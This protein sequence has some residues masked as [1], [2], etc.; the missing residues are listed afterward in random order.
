MNFKSYSLNVVGRIIFLAASMMAFIYALHQ[1]QWYVTT[2]VTGLLIPVLIF[3]LIRYTYRFQKELSF[4]L[5]AIRNREYTQ[6][7]KEGLT[8]KRSEL[9]NAFHV[10]SKE[11]QNV[12]IEKE[13]HYNYLQALVNNINIGI[14]SYLTS[15]EIQLFNKSA[16][17]LLNMPVPKTLKHI[18]AYHPNLYTLLERANPGGKNVLTI[19][20][21]DEILKIAVQVKEFKQQSRIYKLISLQDIR[22]ELDAQELESY[23]KLIQVLRHEIMN[24]VTPIYSL[25]ES[26]KESIEEILENKELQGSPVKEELNDLLIS[27]TTIHTRTNGLLKFVQNYRKLTNVPQPTLK[28]VDLK[29]IVNHSVRLLDNEFKDSRITIHTNL[30]R[31]SLMIICDFDQIQQ[32]IINVLLNAIQA[33]KG[34]K[35]GS[36]TVSGG[37]I[38]EGSIYLIIS[39]NGKGMEEEE[40]EKI[41][42]P[43][44]TTK[45]KGSGIGLSLA[46]KIMKMHQ[47]DIRIYSKPGKGTTCEIVF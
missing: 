32:V 13:V 46:K 37:K 25:S 19:K 44:Y 17:Y 5:M 26:V 8:R 16:S 24:S 12:S 38:S 20:R 2:G 6:Y 45:K 40:I 22:A 27:I 14:I 28:K 1:D 31:E 47:G 11:L 35:D 9:E 21:E 33:L 39:D 36:I 41:F 10:I 34:T 7:Q 15:G 4:F 29:E 3:S 18:E 23:Q 43:F 30:S 42:V